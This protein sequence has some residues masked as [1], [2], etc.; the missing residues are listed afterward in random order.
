MMPLAL[1]NG[2]QQFANFSPSRQQERQI[3][4]NCFTFSVCFSSQ[5]LVFEDGIDVWN[6]DLGFEDIKYFERCCLK[7]KLYPGFNIFSL[8]LPHCWRKRQCTAS[9]NIIFNRV[10]CKYMILNIS[11]WKTKFPLWA[12]KLHGT[13]YV[14]KQ[15]FLSLL[16][17]PHGFTHRII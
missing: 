9:V 3:Q 7:P 8:I 11:S 16:H 15:L 14:G 1:G 12:T 17:A 4:K 5:W 13:L 6:Q 10:Q 2:T